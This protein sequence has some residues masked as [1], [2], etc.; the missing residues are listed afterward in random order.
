MEKELAALSIILFGSF[1]KGESNRESDLDIFVECGK[2]K[3]I[4]L[5]PFEKKLG[6]HIQLF[7]QPNINLLPKNLLNSVVNGIKIKGYFT[8]K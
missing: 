6:H 3:K 1:R 4:N 2:N 7:T 5:V 8:L